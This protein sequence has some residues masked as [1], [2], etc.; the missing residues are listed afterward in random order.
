MPLPSRSRLSWA[1]SRMRSTVGPL[2]GD[3]SCE[4]ALTL[5]LSVVAR[6]AS[7]S[8][9]APEHPKGEIAR[10]KTDRSATS[11][12]RTWQMHVQTALRTHLIPSMISDR[13]LLG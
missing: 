1:P 2:F 10:G 11:A 6:D 4:P 8:P 5:L 7:C 12:P 9:F 3:S 13:R